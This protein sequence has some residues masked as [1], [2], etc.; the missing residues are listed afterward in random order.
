MARRQDRLH[1]HPQAPVGVPAGSPA[2]S[3]PNNSRWPR[4]VARHRAPHDLEVRAGALAP[5]RRDVDPQQVDHPVR[6]E[7]ADLVSACPSAPRRRST[8]RPG[9]SRSRGRGSAGPRSLVRRRGCARRAR[10]RRA[11]CAPRLEVVGLELSEVLRALVVLEDVVAV[12]V[13]AHHR[14]KTSRAGMQ[15]VDQRVDVATRRCRRRGWPAPSRRPPGSAS[16]AGRSDAPPARTRPPGRGARRC[17][18]G[19][20]PPA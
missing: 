8:P 14:P 1:C 15:R 7:L 10:L 20:C 2:A 9:R 13:V 12:E 4:V 18:A 16:A 6:A 3:N 11:G 17:R 5:G 19:A